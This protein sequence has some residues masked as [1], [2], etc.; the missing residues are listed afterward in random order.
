MCFS[1]RGFGA[2]RDFPCT[3]SLPD[4]P[5]NQMSQSFELF[6]SK[7]YLSE[8]GRGSLTQNWDDLIQRKQVAVLEA[9]AQIVAVVKRGATIDHAIVAGTFTFPVFRQRGFA[10][11]LLAFFVQEM[12]KEYAAVKLWVDEDNVEAIALYRAL[13]FQQIGLLY[14]VFWGA[15]AAYRN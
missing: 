6:F 15:I 14:G 10:R 13:G 4:P 7:P 11:R 9:E 3:L 2:F 12:L 5:E 8:R 1:A